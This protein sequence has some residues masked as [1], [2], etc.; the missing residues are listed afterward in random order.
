MPQK[1]RQQRFKAEYTQR[2]PC[3]IKSKLTESHTRCTIYSSDIKI[4]HGG[5]DDLVRHVVARGTWIIK[6]R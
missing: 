2:Y 1:S 4:A 6:G 5:A 3:I